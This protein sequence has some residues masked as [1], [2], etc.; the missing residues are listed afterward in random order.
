MSRTATVWD[1]LRVHLLR[2]LVKV[3][4]ERVQQQEEMYREHP[5]LKEGLHNKSM[6]WSEYQELITYMLPKNTG[7]YAL[8]RV[9]TMAREK[10]ETAKSWCLRLHKGRQRVGRK[11]GTNLSDECYRELLFA[12]LTIREKGELIKAQILRSQEAEHEVGDLV[13]AE[14]NNEGKH[15]LSTIIRV[16]DNG[17][18]DVQYA[19][20]FDNKETNLSEQRKGL[21]F[22]Q[23]ASRSQ[24]DAHAEIHCVG[25]V[26][27][28]NQQRYNM[29]AAKVS[30]TWAKRRAQVI[31]T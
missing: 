23:S 16:R 22:W 14:W 6:P 17:H 12:E 1:Y 24:S 26:G 29:P 8:S 4:L 5:E 7:M 9:L 15:Y 21:R 3:V 25:H 10:D 28:A 27:S 19:D 31:H 2:I 30:G 18:M 20:P 13:M 11:M